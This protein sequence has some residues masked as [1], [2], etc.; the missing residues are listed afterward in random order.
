MLN[1]KQCG[2]TYKK[3]KSTADEQDKFCCKECEWNFEAL[4]EERKESGKF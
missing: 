4:L 1:C 3:E 2:K